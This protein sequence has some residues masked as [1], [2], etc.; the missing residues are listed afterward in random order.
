V[1]AG[2][3]PA[4]NGPRRVRPWRDP[5]DY[6]GSTHPPTTTSH[7]ARNRGTPEASSGDGGVG[8]LRRSPELRG[9]VEPPKDHEHAN[10][11]LASIYGSREE[12]FPTAVPFVRQWL[13]RGE[14][15]PYVADDNT[16]EEVLADVRRD[17]KFR[18]EDHDDEIDVGELPRVRGD[19]SQLRQVFQNLL[20]NALE[21]SGDE[22]PR[23]HVSAERD[24]AA[25]TVAV[26]DEGIGIG[27]EETGR[28]FE[29]FQRL[30]SREAHEGPGIG[31]ALCRRIVDRHGG[32]IRVESDPGEGTTFLVTLPGVD[33]SEPPV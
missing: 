33:A 1:S 29:V 6:S 14:R 3:S 27:P 9:P 13:Q 10:D 12:Q 32:E 23:V 7:D 11:H 5:R 24:G 21:Y 8:A 31:L 20:E 22:P 25:W 4:S 16:T 28:I 19:A 18:I 30:H 26:R 15:C 2:C 17:L